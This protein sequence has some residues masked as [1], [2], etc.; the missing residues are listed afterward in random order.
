MQIWLS[1]FPVSHTSP[2]P[3]HTFTSAEQSVSIVPVEEAISDKNGYNLKPVVV[4][5]K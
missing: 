2:S 3:A 4:L 1:V 5:G